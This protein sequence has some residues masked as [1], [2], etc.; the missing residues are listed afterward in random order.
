MSLFLECKTSP[1]LNYLGRK[2]AQI[3]I[4]MEEHYAQELSAKI[5][6]EAC[7]EALSTLRE[8]SYYR[9]YHVFRRGELEQ[10]L[11][12]IPNI[13]IVESVYDNANWCVVVE[14]KGARPSVYVTLPSYSKII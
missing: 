1:F 13:V 9:Y 7:A 5:M 10:I 6:E 11:A 8:V 12:Q 4:P 3:K 14:K 2:L